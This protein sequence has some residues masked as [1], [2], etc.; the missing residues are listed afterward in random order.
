MTTDRRARRTALLA[1]PRP[2]VWH[3]NHDCTLAQE[4]SAA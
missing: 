2:K 1:G 3:E 4:A